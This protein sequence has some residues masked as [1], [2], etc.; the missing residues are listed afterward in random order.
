M[1]SIKR[2][3]P[4]RKNYILLAGLFAIL[5]SC[6]LI[7]GTLYILPRITSLSSKGENFPDYRELWT[8]RGV[9]SYQ[10]EIVIMSL[11]VPSI[12]L[13]LTIQNN[14]IVQRSIIACDNPSTEF[15]ASDCQLNKVYYSK[16]GNYTVEQLF[17]I[18]DEGIRQ[19]QLS[20]I[21]CN[22]STGSEFHRFSTIEEMTVAI[23]TCQNYLRSSDMLY[24]VE[25]DPYY[26]FPTHIISYMPHVIDGRV[27]I[28]VRNFHVD[29]MDS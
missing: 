22:L 19:T 27:S 3:I 28:T 5:L 16:E 1:M 2:K 20:L 13:E 7:G 25:Y 4:L 29:K 8:S 24:V 14:Q 21:A 23:D 6:F 10:L 9:S 12:G 18:A 26:G 11:P 17:E 15:P